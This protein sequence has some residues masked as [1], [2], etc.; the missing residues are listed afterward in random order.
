MICEGRRSFSTIST[1]CIP[2]SSAVESRR[3]SGAGILAQGT[4][5]ATL[6]PMIVELGHF[7]LVLAFV[8]ACVQM[9]VPM[10]GAFFIDI[11]NALVIQLYLAL[12]WGHPSPE[13]GTIERGIGRSRTNPV[14]MSVEAVRGRP[15][16]ARR[17]AA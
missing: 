14:K 12:V 3:E 17:A 16:P 11:T 4:G 10:V 1:I 8:V 2:L 6:P 13:E 15:R 7:A 5:R 9:V